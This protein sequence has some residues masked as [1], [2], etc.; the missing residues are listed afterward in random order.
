MNVRSLAFAAAI[1]AVPALAAPGPIEIEFWHS[2]SGPL[3]EQVAHLAEKFNASQTRYRVAPVF[4]GGHDELAPA[5]LAAYHAGK[6]P[7]LVQVSDVGTAAMA[8][9]TKAIKPVY[10]L[11]ASAGEKFD[12]RA[13]FPAISG[14]YSDRQGRLLALPFNNSTAV[15]YF[16]KDAFRKAGIDPEQAPHTWRDVQQAALKIQETGATECGITSAL[17]SWVQ[18]ENISAWHDQPIATSNNGFGGTA[19]RLNFSSELLIRHISLLSSWAKSRLFTYA[20]R[21]REAEAKFTGG[22]CAMLTTSSDALGTITKNARFAFGVAPLPYYDEFRGAPFNTIVDGDG[23]WVMAGRNPADYKGVAKFFSFLMQPEVQADWQQQTGYLPTTLAASELL[24]KQGFYDLNPGAYVP[25]KEVT[26]KKTSL[27]RGLRLGNLA[28]IRTVIDEELE[29]VW[30]Q[31]K[32]PKEALDNA[33]ERGNEF[34]SRFERA[35]KR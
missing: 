34:L 1:I 24:R 33:V 20:G 21:G 30:N 17:Q 10:Q 9:E 2:M 3:G 11:M 26:G 23:L 25:L 22:E 18:V 31:T 4:K 14:H 19:A 29:G 16:N 32:T 13:F 5:A 12:S 35:K 15:F 6:P 27:S 7:L 8:E 28:N